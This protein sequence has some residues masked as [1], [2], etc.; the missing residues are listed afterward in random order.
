MMISTQVGNEEHPVPG[1]QGAAG[2]AAQSWEP[3]KSPHGIC[4]WHSSS[5]SCSGA[6]EGGLGRAGAQCGASSMWGPAGAVGATSV[7]VSAPTHPGVRTSP[8]VSVKQPNLC[9]ALTSKPDTAVL[10][11]LVLQFPPSTFMSSHQLHSLC[12]N[13][14]ALL[15][16]PTRVHDSAFGLQNPTLQLTLHPESMQCSA[17]CAFLPKYFPFAFK[18]LKEQH[19]QRVKHAA[20]QAGTVDTQNPQLQQVSSFNIL[21]S[22]GTFMH[23]SYVALITHYN[24][25]VHFIFNYNAYKDLVWAVNYYN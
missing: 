20:I 1:V 16:P 10:G 11:A 7:T 19:Q 18:C 23:I 22:F 8:F 5:P 21:M 17:E 3:L 4:G 13:C 24:S 14:S 9:K 12:Y 25:N 2:G 6:A 15:L